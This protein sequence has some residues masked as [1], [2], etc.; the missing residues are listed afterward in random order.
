MALS[1][2]KQQEAADIFKKYRWVDDLDDV[3]NPYFHS[4]YNGKDTPGSARLN[5]AYK[6]AAGIDI[7]H[8]TSYLIQF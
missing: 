8:R 2:G 6:E 3:I 5:E 4:R 7:E 1:E